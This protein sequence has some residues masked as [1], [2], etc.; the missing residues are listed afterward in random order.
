MTPEEASLPFLTRKMLA[1][2]HGAAFSLIVDLLASSSGTYELRGFTKEGPF[3]FR[4]VATGSLA[5]ESF[6][7]RIPDFPIFFTVVGTASTV[8]VNEAGVA[9]FLGVNGTRNI[10][11]VSGQP[12]LSYGVNWPNP[13]IPSFLHT[14]G[15]IDDTVIANPGTGAEISFTFPDSTFTLIKSISFLY[16]AGAAAATRRVRLEIIPNGSDIVR[17]ASASDIIISEAWLM[18]W[19]PGAGTIIDTTTKLQ[20]MSFPND[21]LI[22]PSSTLQTVTTAF[23]ALDAI[24]SIQISGEQFYAQ[25]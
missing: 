17:V 16:T 1:F 24:T 19:Y 8:A 23:N 5:T 18:V 20:Q 3:N 13:G 11:L 25:G 21:L 9:V 12:S 4:F 14:R 10:M 2:E 15:R 7:F 22:P 6:T